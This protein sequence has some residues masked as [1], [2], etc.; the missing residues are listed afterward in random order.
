MLAMIV[1]ILSGFA[2]MVWNS[3]RTER[4]RRE[5]GEDVGTPGALRWTR[6]DLERR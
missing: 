2:F 3:Y 6:D 5:R 4:D 1:A